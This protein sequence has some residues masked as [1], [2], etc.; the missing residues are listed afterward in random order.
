MNSPLSHIEAERQKSK[1]VNPRAIWLM[2]LCVA[3]LFVICL[4]AWLQ[5]P[6]SNQELVANFA[7]AGDF[8]RAAK[9]VGGI[10]WWSPMFMQGTSLA[11]DW[12]FML[13]NAVLLAFSGTLGFLAGSKV[14]VAVC[15][16]L[17]ALGMHFFLQRYT[18][19]RLS[20]LMGGGLFLFAPSVLTRAVGFEHFVVLV[21]LALLP[22]VF[23]SLTG[24][25]RTRTAR[26]AVVFAVFFSALTMAYGKTGLMAAPV[27]LAF[28]LAE[29]FFSNSKKR[30]DW[31]IF[32]LAAFF[33]FWLAVVPNLPTLRE[34]HFITM[35]EMGPFAGWQQAFS[36]KSAVSWLDR[37]T[38]LGGG[39]ARGFAPTTLNG[40]T[41]LGLVTFFILALALGARRLEGSVA[42]RQSRIFIGLAMFAFWLSFGPR[43][44]LGGHMEF[45]GLSMEAADFLPAL[46]W[47]LLAGQVWILFRLLAPKGNLG[48][49]LATGISIV[50]LV[51]PGFRL[52][53]LLPLYKNIRAPFDFF[54]VTGAIC[55]IAGTAMAAGIL[56][57]RL[58]WRMAKMAAATVLVLLAA[59]DVAPYARSIFQQQMDRAV[60]GDFLAAQT[61][62]KS[63]PQSGRVYAFSG[64][65]FYLLTPWLSGRP[66]ANEAFNSYLQQR[67]AALLQSSAMLSEESWKSYLRIAG[68][69]YLL[70]DKTDPD[71]PKEL[72]EKMR[73]NFVTV[74]E[75]ANMAVLAVS[76]S[77]GPCFLAR[78]YV[79]TSNEDA[80]SAMGSLG[81]ARYN[82]AAI[83]LTGADLEAPGYQ[84]KIVDGRIL[85]KE[86]AAIQEGTHFL[87]IPQKSNGN[88]QR[89]TFAASEHPGWLVM[90][91]AWHPDWVAIQDG[92]IEKPQRAFLA[93]PAVQTDGTHE[94]TFEF[95]QPWWYNV[96]IYIGCASWL[97]ALGFLITGGGRLSMECT[98]NSD[99][100]KL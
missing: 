21:S 8:F 79:Q 33:I 77:L 25:M 24:L 34:V 17:G 57:E 81:A 83:Q 50:Y 51:V 78:D 40:G 30:S 80:P 87:S 96:C 41:Y 73:L 84:G 20:A 47:F 66:L 90:N 36:T 5:Q 89:A 52:L 49:A 95:R 6:V 98:Q 71:N 64:R 12:S 10:P 53:E 67:G 16:A 62:L 56:L 26:S 44:V 11:M 38:L 14:A 88:Y 23:W 43:S 75:N 82:Y 68:V 42:G 65:Y 55:L 58:P 86:K 1:I 13:T 29:Y 72:Q 15:L 85:P 100:L 99:T 18:E 97:M 9:S 93:F 32:G 59:W 70:I 69:A 3:A 35:F 91:Q 61:F 2:G 19:N 4:F 60:F 31:K 45:L 48:L 46:G 28:G 37:D 94:V 39:M 22:W 76:E 27:L 74:F 54:Q 7:K 92:K 63:A